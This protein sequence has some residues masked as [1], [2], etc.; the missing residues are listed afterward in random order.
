MHFKFGQQYMNDL[1]IQ[2]SQ[3]FKL[4]ANNFWLISAE[5]EH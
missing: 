3:K 1:L 5:F 2:T 4:M